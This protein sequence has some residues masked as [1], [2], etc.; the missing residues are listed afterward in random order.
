M[1]QAIISGAAALAALFSAAPAAGNPW[2]AAEQHRAGFAGATLR[3]SLGGRSA[4]VPE[5]R[6]GVGF[7]HYR[8][9]GGG[10]MVS[11]D[12]P[13]LPV[14]TGFSGGRLEFFVGGRSLVQ[15]EREH[16][17]GARSTTFMLVIGGLAAG[18]AAVLLLTDRDQQDGPCPP[19]VEVCAN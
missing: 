10:F 2:E 3:L 7:S 18:A 8:R 16:R 12:G 5:A 6:L 19:G 11:R 17:L 1:R 13:E 14:A 9:D 15:L 4:T